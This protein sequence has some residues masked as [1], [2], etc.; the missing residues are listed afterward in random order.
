FGIGFTFGPLIAAGSQWLLP[1]HLEAIG[2]SAAAISLV[3]LVLG[4]RIMPE[5]RRFDAAPT[6]K[7]KIIDFTAV[8]KA[9]ASASIGP[10]VLTFFL[11]SLGFAAFEATLSLLLV[12][13]FAFDIGFGFLVFAYI[14]FVLMLTQGLLYRRL[15]RRYSEVVLMTLGI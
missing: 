3:A 14:G 10:V 15:A 7:R 1:N 4:I 6:Q 5:T 2:Y 12:E 11:A 8:R 13:V 9:V